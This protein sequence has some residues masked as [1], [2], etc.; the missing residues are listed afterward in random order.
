[1]GGDKDGGT[2]GVRK[3][4]RNLRLKKCM[5]EYG[6]LKIRFEYNDKGTARV[7]ME[8]SETYEYPSLISTFFDTHTYDGVFAI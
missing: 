5:D 6:P 7:Q 2:K 4:T 1:M 3:E 8:S